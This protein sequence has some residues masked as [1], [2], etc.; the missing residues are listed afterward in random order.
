[1]SSY[2]NY[3]LPTILPDGSVWA[4]A[5]SDT[6]DLP[7]LVRLVFDGQDLMYFHKIGHTDSP[8]HHLESMYHFMQIL[9]ETELIP[10]LR[11]ATVDDLANHFVPS[12]ITSYGVP[13]FFA[14]DEISEVLKGLNK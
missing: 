11:W 12:G 7:Y 9:R 4:T 14:S 10:E 2:T 13:D 3:E 1:M 5:T 6:G 8:A